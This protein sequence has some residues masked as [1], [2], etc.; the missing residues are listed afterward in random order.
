MYYTQDSRLAALSQL[1]YIVDYMRPINILIK[2]GFQPRALEWSFAEKMQQYVTGKISLKDPSV[3]L[4]D[5][6]LYHK[7]IK[8]AQKSL[9]LLSLVTKLNERTNTGG[10]LNG[11]LDVAPL[12][13]QEKRKQYKTIISFIN[14]IIAV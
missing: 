14:Y 10:A 12:S 9:S 7:G 2:A 13:Q 11:N 1:Y 8:K 5:G 6:F 4:V 3:F